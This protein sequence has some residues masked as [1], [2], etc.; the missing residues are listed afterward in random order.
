MSTFTDKDEAISACIGAT[1]ELAET[2]IAAKVAERGVLIAQF[3][4]AAHR[5]SDIDK[6][7]AASV[8]SML[9]NGLKGGR[10][11]ARRNQDEAGHPD[12]S[13]KK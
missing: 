9:A 11:K 10:P 13:P 5:N 1:L 2:M 6:K 3:T 8:F 7:D 4:N 12:Q